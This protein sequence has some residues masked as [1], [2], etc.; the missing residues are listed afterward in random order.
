[1]TEAGSRVDA[2]ST[3]A[4]RRALVAVATQFFVNGT[5]FA[6]FMPRLPEIRDQI[7]ITVDRVGLLI[8]LAGLSGLVGSLT[9]GPAISRFGT[10]RVMSGTAAIIALTLPV[11]GFARSQAVLLVALAVMMGLDVLVDVAMNMQGSWLSARRHAPVMSRLHGL[12]SLGTVIGGLAA[13]RIAAAGIP[14]STHLPIAAAVLLLAVL[15]VYQWALP[16][17]EPSAT[18]PMAATDEGSGRRVRSPA[19][20]SVL[21]LFVLAGM[22]AL[23]VEATT[24]DWAAFRFAD[25]FGLAAGDAALGYVAVTVGMTVGRFGGDWAAQRLGADGLSVLSTVLTGAGLAVATLIDAVWIGRIGF[26]LAGLGI[27]VM[28]PTIYD[29]AAKHPGRPGVGLGALTAGLR[30]AVILFPFLVGWLASTTLSVGA[31]MAIVTLPSVVAFALVTAA[32]PPVG[33]YPDS[34]P[35][36]DRGSSGPAGSA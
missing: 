8:S 1:M 22:S 15:F 13:A 31:A 17:D 9:V 4:D 7:G 24:I 33:V 5:V 19:H 14:L 27:A 11:I 28:L 18:A 23:A 35:G 25:D 16:V 34:G 32:L 2:V 6:S 12:W 36:I 29:R 10:R 26:V 3:P 21:A 30:V 20:R